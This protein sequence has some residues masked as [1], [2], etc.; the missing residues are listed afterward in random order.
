MIVKNFCCIAIVYYIPLITLHYFI[1]ITLFYTNFKINWN[2]GITQLLPSSVLTI[3]NKE[4][5]HGAISY[6]FRNTNGNT[7]SNSNNS[8]NDVKGNSAISDYNRRPQNISKMLKVDKV[9]DIDL[10]FDVLKKLNEYGQKLKSRYSQH[11][12][13]SSPDVYNKAVF[14]IGQ[15]VHHIPS[16]C[17]CVI[18]G[19]TTKTLADYTIILM[20][21]TI[22]LIDCTIIL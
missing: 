13:N 10:M 9:D 18:T 20:H 21:S 5:V 7:D 22:I 14:E 4:G 17:R 12:K 19:N 2:L 3:K 6:C 8:S 16:N 11:V 15:I 1:L